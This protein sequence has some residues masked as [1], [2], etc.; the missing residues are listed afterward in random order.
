[1]VMVILKTYMFKAAMVG[2]GTAAV[3]FELPEDVFE[4]GRSRLARRD[5]E[6]ETHGLPVVMVRILPQQDRI[7][8]A[9]LPM[10][11]E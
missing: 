6:A 9:A 8:P 11:Y 2:H 4:A 5:R 1:M 10:V 3:I 7:E